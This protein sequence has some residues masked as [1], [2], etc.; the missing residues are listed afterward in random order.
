[1]GL[2][3]LCACAANNVASIQG[4]EK[5]SSGGKVIYHEVLAQPRFR[6]TNVTSQ[7][8]WFWVLKKM[9]FCRISSTG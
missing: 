8:M 3:R 5:A 4:F 6:I 7:C 1:V 2:G 9:R